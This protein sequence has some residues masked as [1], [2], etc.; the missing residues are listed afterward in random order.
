MLA[1]GRHLRM[2][3]VKCL[4]TTLRLPLR[5]PIH[6]YMAKTVAL[7]RSINLLLNS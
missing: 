5:S 2:T 4:V 3:M 7:D 1:G 6:L